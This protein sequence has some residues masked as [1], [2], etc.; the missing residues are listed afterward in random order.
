MISPRSTLTVKFLNR[1][2]D[3]L[4]FTGIGLAQLK[5]NSLMEK[6]VKDGLSDW[7]R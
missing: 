3:F 5:A 1:K 4:R 2:D 6:A 7:G